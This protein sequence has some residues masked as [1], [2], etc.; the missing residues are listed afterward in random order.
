MTHSHGNLL[1][2][3]LVAFPPFC[4]CCNLR[5]LGGCIPNTAASF[6]ALLGCCCSDFASSALRLCLESPFGLLGRTFGF[7]HEVLSTADGVAGAGPFAYCDLRRLRC[8]QWSR[9]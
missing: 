7:G 1:L 8:V 3:L 5:V 6:A 4:A 9:Q 2:Q